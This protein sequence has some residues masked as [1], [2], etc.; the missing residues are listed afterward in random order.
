[1]NIANIEKITIK[2]VTNNGVT[3][4]TKKGAVIK[5]P[6]DGGVVIDVNPKQK[7]ITVAFPNKRI[8]RFVGIVSPTKKGKRLDLNEKICEADGSIKV[9]ASVD[10]MPADPMNEFNINPVK[11]TR[12]GANKDDVMRLQEE[13]KALG[14]QP[15]N[16]ADI[17][18]GLYNSTTPKFT[19]PV[20]NFQYPD[21]SKWMLSESQTNQI[22]DLLSKQKSEADRLKSQQI[23]TQGISPEGLSFMREDVVSGVVPGL[24]RLVPSDTSLYQQSVNTNTIP[25]L[26]PVTDTLA[27]ATTPMQ[28]APEVTV[29]QA[30][31]LQDSM[32]AQEAMRY[33][34]LGAVGYYQQFQQQP[35]KQLGIDPAFATEDT[36]IKQ[37]LGD[38]I[39]TSLTDNEL[40]IA[41]LN[42]RKQL[43][44]EKQINQSAN[45][46]QMQR[47]NLGQFSAMQNPALRYN[48]T[49]NSGQKAYYDLVN[50]LRVNQDISDADVQRRK[51]LLGAQDIGLQALLASSNNANT[52]QANILTSAQNA[53][54]QLRSAFVQQQIQEQARQQG[55][56]DQ[57]SLL[58][59]QSQAE[60]SAPPT[61]SE[62]IVAL[63]NII[64]D[65]T[66]PEA[67]KAIYRQM[68]LQIQ[69]QLVR[70]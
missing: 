57:A 38:T 6:E 14:F 8:I 25:G 22:F 69:Q 66:V 19:E 41:R 2:K 56:V 11:N 20:N 3:L 60:A 23:T 30:Q 28:V 42:V 67:D 48:D 12:T 15:L 34:N 47:F 61:L 10:D 29:P 64:A 37:A 40:A 24:T 51:E 65:P 53:D 70:L 44:T 68:L 43:E 16:P 45:Q 36:Y 31:S 39:A 32:S 13:I 4:A 35:S 50:Q 49:R 33:Q 58:K 62:K 52:R 27:P 9:Y 1:M 21:I 55:L 46:E 26:S 5:S 54:T 59:A 63:N 7:S 17:T 18:S